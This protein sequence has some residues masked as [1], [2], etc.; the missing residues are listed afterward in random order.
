LF[1]QGLRGGDRDFPAVVQGLF[2]SLELRDGLGVA[3]FN[4]T[5]LKI[6]FSPG[7]PMSKLPGNTRV[8]EIRKGSMARLPDTAQVLLTSRPE[9]ID[10]PSHEEPLGQDSI[11]GSTLGS[12]L[13]VH[14]DSLSVAGLEESVEC[15][16]ATGSSRSTFFVD[17]G[18]GQCFCSVSDAFSDLQPC[19]IEVTRVSGSFPIYGCGTANFVALDQNG[20]LVIRR[21]PNCLF[22]RCEFNLLSVSQRNQ[23]RGNRL[24]FGLDSPEM[25]L[26]PPSGIFCPSV[27]APLALEDGLFALHLEPLGEGDPRFEKLPKYTITLKGKF[28]P[29]DS[30]GVVRW[31]INVLA[32]ATSS[33]RLLAGTSEDCHDHLR[34]FCDDYFAHPKFSQPAGFMISNRRRIWL[35]FRF[36]FS[37]LLRIAWSGPWKSAMAY[38][39]IRYYLVRCIVLTGNIKLV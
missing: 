5:T 19:R 4:A 1:G 35:S 25:V 14:G 3:K 29:S 9:V 15:L 17:S 12:D 33:V 20:A 32:M 13:G 34:A 10:S 26:A 23:V 2:S 11:G 18:A 24:D 22:G 38:L 16:V 36:V 7:V 39:E 37:G 6:E 27:R 28:V 30:G 21:I 31:Q 8:K